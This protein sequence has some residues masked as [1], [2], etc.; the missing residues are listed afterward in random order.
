MKKV[1]LVGKRLLEENDGTAIVALNF[2]I[3]NSERTE[4]CKELNIDITNNI[5]KTIAWDIHYETDLRQSKWNYTVYDYK[6]VHCYMITEPQRDVLKKVLNL[7]EIITHTAVEGFDEYEYFILY[8]SEKEECNKYELECLLNEIGKELLKK[9]GRKEIDDFEVEDRVEKYNNELFLKKLYE[10]VTNMD[11]PISI[12]EKNINNFIPDIETFLKELEELPSSNKTLKNEYILTTEPKNCDCSLESGIADD[13][14]HFDHHKKEHSHYPAPSNNNNIKAISNKKVAISHIDADTFIG[15]LRMEGLELPKIDLD[16]VEKIDLNGSSV[17]DDL[18][19]DT[20]YY[21]VGVGEF[22]RK[23]QFPKIE[24]NKDIDVTQYICELIQNQN[25][26]INLGKKATNK[27]ITD[28]DNAITHYAKR[29]GLLKITPNMS[30]D[31]SMGYKKGMDIV[32][33]YREHYKSISIYVNPKIDF[34]ARQVWAG[35]EF[36]GHEKACGSPR[37]VEYTFQNAIDVF[38]QVSWTY[39][40]TK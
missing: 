26:F 21:M 31:P 24:K 19:N 23:I 27:A 10:K 9:E 39:F 6:K 7:R 28:F 8:S 14:N 1:L 37:G 3:N 12:L 30:I 4:L 18:H 17:L 36:G 40:E 32:I 16:L 34:V 35:I 25:S 38:T 5:F 20:Y 13:Q 2:N 11:I 29:V 22:A 15:I 33:I